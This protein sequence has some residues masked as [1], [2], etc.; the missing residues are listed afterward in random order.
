MFFLSLASIRSHK[1]LSTLLAKEELTIFNPKCCSPLIVAME[2][3]QLNN[4][5]NSFTFKTLHKT[6]IC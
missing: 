3:W 2:G 5:R 6:F 1:K 4:I